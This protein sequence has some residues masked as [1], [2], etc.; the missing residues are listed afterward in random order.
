MIGVFGGSFDPIH[1][2]HLRLAV[3]LVESLSFSEI[4]FV[5]ARQPP[6]RPTP[7]ASPEQRLEMLK[8]ALDDLGDSR[9]KVSEL[10][11]RREG[12]S[13]MAD[14]LTAMMAE[15]P[16]EPLV[17]I[18]GMDAFNGFPQWHRPDA[19]LTMAHLLV[20]SRAGARPVGE[21]ESWL[22][23]RRAVDPVMLKRAR[24]GSILELPIA[25][26]DVSAS[27]LRQIALLSRDLHYLTPEPVREYIGQ[28]R[29]YL[30]SA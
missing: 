16:P 1:I 29:L 14:T 19:I 20:A 10:E 5:P 23:Q 25:R 26:L 18:L 30:K 12:P 21:A 11:L 3:E 28:Q 22:Q 15:R 6:H 4:R 7:A 9:L 17:L 13:Y 8:L 24:A 27:Q 2:G